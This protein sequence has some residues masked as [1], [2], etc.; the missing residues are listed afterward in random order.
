[1]TSDINNLNKSPNNIFSNKN[2][3]TSNTSTPTT[4]PKRTL[5]RSKFSPS[6]HEHEDLSGK[7]V[8]RLK[9]LESEP[10]SD[11]S[12]DV[13][14]YKDLKEL[15]KRREKDPV[16]AEAI[17]SQAEL[18]KAERTAKAWLA[19]QDKIQ[20]R[21]LRIVQEVIDGGILI[22]L[23]EN[24]S[25]ELQNPIDKSLI[26]YIDP[27]SLNNLPPNSLLELW[28]PDGN[29]IPQIDPKTL[30]NL[31]Q[32]HFLKTKESLAHA[33]LQDASQNA[34][35]N[36]NLVTPIE[37]N[38]LKDLKEDFFLELRDATNKTLIAYV[39]PESLKNISKN[40]LIE[41]RDPKDGSLIAYYKENKNGE[42]ASG[43]MEKFIWD[44]AFIF[45]VQDFFVRTKESLIQTKEGAIEGG[46]PWTKQ[47]EEGA[48]SRDVW[49]QKPGMDSPELAQTETDYYYRQGSFQIAQKGCLLEDY[50]SSQDPDPDLPPINQDSLLKATM[51]S[52]LFS[53]FDAHTENIIVDEKGCIKFFDN[54]RSFPNSNGFVDWLIQPIPAFQ[55]ELISLRENM[56]P[57]TA[58][59]RKMMKEELAGYQKHLKEFEA[60]I[61]S[62]ATSSKIKNLPVGWLDKKKALKAFKERIKNME[63][64]LSN[65]K[66]ISCA[67]LILACDPASIFLFALNYV[68][69]ATSDKGFLKKGGSSGQHIREALE[70]MYATS[71][72]DLIDATKY[73]ISLLELHELFKDPQVNLNS[74]LKHVIS[75][76]KIMQSRDLKFIGKELQEESEYE[77]KKVLASLKNNAA[78]DNKDL[79]AEDS[80]ICS[81][82]KGFSY[83]K[84]I[85]ES[86]SNPDIEHIIHV[87]K[88]HSIR[89]PLLWINTAAKEFSLFL[90]NEEG[91]FMINLLDVKTKPGSVIVNELDFFDLTMESTSDPILED[92]Q[93]KLQDYP[94]R[95]P[96]LWVNTQKR[97]FTLFYLTETNDLIEKKL[98]VKTKPQ[99]IVGKTQIVSFAEFSALFPTT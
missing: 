72:S 6:H 16:T 1:M 21:N 91:K 71:L 57:L 87:L 89:T 46:K 70:T 18:F 85:Q 23:P 81:A 73:H 40:T 32:N 56:I 52:Y 82:Y 76:L 26:A 68:A 48:I 17:L 43:I 65:E 98:D 35:H 75:E 37:L 80:Y 59:N 25:L 7:L 99:S 66:N 45:K 94:P 54:T 74:V 36:G 33:K 31:T 2:I 42:R 62:P 8:K 10:K 97:E 96:L 41:L 67:D 88:H 95:K 84:L 86:E 51:A 47:T 58:E 11:A 5:K 13:P 20:S 83:L 69:I 27:V 14:N 78:L 50:L 24:S 44:M 61:K 39:D 34:V 63:K 3:E 77:A 9:T 12:A 93:A 22:S 55:C 49:Q 92:V 15:K 19:Q 90:I 30:R 53:M 29:L 28:D 38:N 60:F 64:A 4:S 79:S